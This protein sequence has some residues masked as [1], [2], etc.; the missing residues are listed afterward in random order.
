[1]KKKNFGYYVRIRTPKF[2]DISTPYLSKPTTAIA[3]NIH[4]DTFT[5][6]H[7]F[8]FLD[9]EHKQ[10]KNRSNLN[11]NVTKKSHEKATPSFTSAMEIH[12]S[13]PPYAKR[14]SA[15]YRV[16][17]C[18]MSSRNMVAQLVC[19][20]LVVTW[21][22]AQWRRFCNV[23]VTGQSSMC[24]SSRRPSLCFEPTRGEG[25]SSFF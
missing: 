15:Q 23:L 9:Y 19:W 1:M 12:K 22:F 16:R 8:F 14:T 7:K 13:P 24:I 4:N 3:R 18:Q 25:L 11:T 6:R 21:S 17:P 5:N 20:L 10:S 2:F